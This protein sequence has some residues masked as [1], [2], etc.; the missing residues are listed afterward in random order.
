MGK[1][2]DLTGRRF[3]KLTVLSWA[4]NNK[5]NKSVWRCL[6]DC[7]NPDVYVIGAN[8]KSGNSTQCKECKAR[9][10]VKH[11]VNDKRILNIWN[12]IKQRCYNQNHDAYHHYGGRGIKMCDEWL[13]NAEEFEIWANKNGYSKD[14]TI[15]RIEVNGNYEP[16]NCRW[17]TDDEQQSNRRNNVL[18]TFNGETKTVRQWEGVS[19][20]SRTTIQKR[21]FNG[22]TDKDK[23]FAPPVKKKATKTSGHKGVTYHLKTNK[24]EV[25]H[26]CKFIDSFDDLEDA[27]KR[28]QEEMIKDPYIRKQKN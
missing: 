24:W 22:E 14:L 15:D 23:I 1:I 13:N 12:G 25:H 5:H 9:S 17:A 27:I 2:E 16:S 8:L 6:C 19:E 20:V 28:K 21:I 26:K 11:S 10:M 7:T 4:E 18:L 3:G